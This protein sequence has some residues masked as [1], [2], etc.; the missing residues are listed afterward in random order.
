M[1]GKVKFISSISV[2]GE[3]YVRSVSKYLGKKKL[4]AQ[5]FTYTTIFNAGY[6]SSQCVLEILNKVQKDES[7]C[8]KYLTYLGFEKREIDR[9]FNSGERSIYRF[10]QMPTCH[11]K[12]YE[13]TIVKE[14]LEHA[15]IDVKGT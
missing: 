1:F 9:L 4:Q 10:L 15:G 5:S 8:R 2:K 14:S 11:R 13:K 12:D 7:T 3:I 6:T